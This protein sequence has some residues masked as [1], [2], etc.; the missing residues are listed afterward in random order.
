MAAER[1]LREIAHV[2]AADQDLP[3][4]D[5]V[6]AVD[7]RHGAGLAGAGRADQRHRL[8]RLD[9]EAHVAQHGHAGDVAEGHV[10][11]LDRAVDALRDRARP[12]CP[13]SRSARPA[14]RRCAAPTPSRAA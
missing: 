13:G 14:P 11:E 10:A 12:A 8:A 5:V 9:P 6:E 2:V 4:P 3:A 7:Q 1:G